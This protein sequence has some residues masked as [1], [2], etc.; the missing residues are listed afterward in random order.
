MKFNKNFLFINIFISFLFN[1][2]IVSSQIDETKIREPNIREEAE[3]DIPAQINPT[4]IPDF[5]LFADQVKKDSFQNGIIDISL[6]S[7]LKI[8]IDDALDIKKAMLGDYFKAHVAE[9]FY[10]S[11]EPP[12]LIVPKGSWVRGNI[13]Y[14]KKPGIFSKNAKIKVKLNKI[15]SP[16]GEVGEVVGELVFYSGQE[17]DKE[18]LNILMQ[19]SKSKLPQLDWGVDDEVKINAS[20]VRFSLIKSLLDR[21]LIALYQNLNDNH[22][23]N[24]RQELQVLL[25]K[26]I[27]IELN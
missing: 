10:L 22:I 2:N 12:H 14:I 4:S 8:T 7:K 17:N 11:T 18:I 19:A 9:D 3:Q 1:A 15:I 24:K 26:R 21:P 23:L 16:N 20:Q 25:K 6:N 13:S 27:I 5:P